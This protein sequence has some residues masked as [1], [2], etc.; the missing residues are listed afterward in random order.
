MKFID[1]SWIGDRIALGIVRIENW[2]DEKR[3]R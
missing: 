1:G 2:F 3:S